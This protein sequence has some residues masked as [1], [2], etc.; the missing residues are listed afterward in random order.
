MITE[1]FDVGGSSDLSVFKGEDTTTQN[2]GSRDA[3]KKVLQNSVLSEA[4]VT[5]DS[6][7]GV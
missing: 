3:T 5:Q 2:S 1:D 7:F 6:G 4:M